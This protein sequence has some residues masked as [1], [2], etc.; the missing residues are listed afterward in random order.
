MTN[1]LDDRLQIK[2]PGQSQNIQRSRQHA[3]EITPGNSLKWLLFPSPTIS[4]LHRRERFLEVSLNYM[5]DW[6]PGEER[7]HD[8]R[9]RQNI[10][11]P[12]NQ[13]PD[14][15]A[16]KSVLRDECRYADFSH[17]SSIEEQTDTDTSNT[18]SRKCIKQNNIFIYLYITHQQICIDGG[19]QQ[20][21]G[22]K[23]QKRS[24]A[25]LEECEY[26]MWQWNKNAMIMSVQLSN[27]VYSTDYE[28]KGGKK[29]AGCR[30]SLSYP[31]VGVQLGRQRSPH[32]QEELSEI[33][34]L[35]TE[36]CGGYAPPHTKSTEQ[37]GHW[38]TSEDASRTQEPWQP[39]TE[40]A[41]QKV[42]GRRRDSF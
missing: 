41:D 31:L 22:G 7:R 34:S 15:L 3:V 14:S 30:R 17:E 2:F 42:L 6:S 27:C 12:E 38:Q 26:I 19:R 13:L 9:Q 16:G 4:R 8:R 28:V 25:A 20:R 32:Q 37:G 11:A 39:G 35:R 10:P 18:K 21:C 33:L 5:C 24:A 1:Q 23:K 36:C 40:P 29:V